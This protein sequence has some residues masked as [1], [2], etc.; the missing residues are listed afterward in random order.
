MSF[1]INRDTFA[2]T[3]PAEF[4]WIL[5]NS[6]SNNFARSLLEQV[7]RRGELSE[8]QVAAVTRNLQPREPEVVRRM[9]DVVAFFQQAFAK[10][11]KKPVI[12]GIS[13]GRTYHFTVA[14]PRGK[15]AGCFYVKRINLTPMEDDY[16]G[17]ITPE[18]RFYPSRDATDVD[19]HALEYVGMDVMSAVRN[20][21]EQY[22]NCGFCGLDLTDP[23]SVALKYGPICAKKYDL[24][25]DHE[26]A[27]L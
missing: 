7:D 19:L 6:H 11:A 4:E 23:V 22:G 24:P 27:G 2:V 8:K 13:Q 16:M 15:N 20:Y 3:N 26:A 12:R 21:G 17:K 1:Q 9:D 5:K 25:H 10:G 18:G 14:S